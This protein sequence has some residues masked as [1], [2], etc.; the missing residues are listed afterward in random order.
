MITGL[1]SQTNRRKDFSGGIGGARLIGKV[2][3]ST[4]YLNAPGNSG[5]FQFDVADW[6]DDGGFSGSIAFTAPA[7]GIYL[8]EALLSSSEAIG[9]DGTTYQIVSSGNIIAVKSA[10]QGG[11]TGLL[12]VTFAI[13]PGP[14][15]THHYFVYSVSG[16]AKLNAG[17][18]ITCIW[19][20]GGI[21]AQA[22]IPASVQFSVYLLPF[23][24]LG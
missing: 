24:L 10:Q 1:Q 12:P 19:A 5:T 17:A 16:L 2:H 8:C 13:P 15:H 23:P 4:G 14:P 7:N 3:I 21:P 20:I 6:N 18:V 11:D 9:S 22:Y